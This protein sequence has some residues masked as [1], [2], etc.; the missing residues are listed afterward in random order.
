MGGGT[1]GGGRRNW[2]PKIDRQQSG[3]IR[4]IGKWR[5]D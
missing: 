4:E 1:A 2:R 5:E 3:W